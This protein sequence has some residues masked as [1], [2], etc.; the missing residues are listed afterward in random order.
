MDSIIKSNSYKMHPIGVIRTSFTVKGETPIQPIFSSSTGTIEVFP[1]YSDGLIDLEG[2]SH[3][4]IIYIFDRSKTYQLRV[5]PFLDN[6]PHGLFS[7]RHP[8]RPN[9]IGISI[10]QIIDINKNSIVVEG[11]D[12]LDNTPLLDIKPYIPDFDIRKN[13]RTGW[14]KQRRK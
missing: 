14:Y 7:T 10:V 12:V 13:A 5:K 3:I 9:P 8:N 6:H 2:F 1:Q 11:I 4:F